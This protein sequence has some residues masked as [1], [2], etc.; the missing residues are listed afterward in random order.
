MNVNP[1]G[2]VG[3]ILS[4]YGLL[5]APFAWTVFHVA[6][7]GIATG[8]CS[9]FGVRTGA[10]PQPWSFALMVVC[11][12]VALGALLAAGLVWLSTRGVEDDADPPLGRIHFLAVVGLVITPL[13]ITIIV[14]AGLGGTALGCGQG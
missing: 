9:P 10:D 11:G 5:G 7:V 13:F 2:L 4:W 12:L 14:M 8:A 3:R 1:T 6:G